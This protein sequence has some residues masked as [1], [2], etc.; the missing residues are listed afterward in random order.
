MLAFED[1]GEDVGLRVVSLCDIETL[2]SLGLVN[3]FFRRLT[4]AK[5]L[6][7]LLVEDLASRGLV[8]L[9]HSRSLADHSVM[10]LIGLV[11]RTVIG[12]ATWSEQEG[13]PVL[14]E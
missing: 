11:K 7:I 3:V 5:Q 6:W 12:P 14:A 13:S 8:D 2:L 10:D 9:P 1:L 4:M